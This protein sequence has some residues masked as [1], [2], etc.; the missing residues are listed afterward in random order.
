M[1]IQGI[2][3]IASTFRNS[4]FSSKNLSVQSDETQQSNVQE[5]DGPPPGPS[6]SAPPELNIDTDGDDLWSESEMSMFSENM[7]LSIDTSEIISM[8]DTDGDGKISAE[9]EKAMAEDNAFNLSAPS[10]S[11]GSTEGTVSSEQT[12]VQHTSEIF[13][14]MMLAYMRSGS[15]QEGYSSLLDLAL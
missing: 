1:T 3:S 14:Q 13:N 9:E 2:S 6:P 10:E 4:Y 5:I 7:G 12:E 8:Y 11:L 15:E